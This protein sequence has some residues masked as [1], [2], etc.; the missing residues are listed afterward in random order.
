MPQPEG[1]ALNQSISP[2]LTQ[3][4]IGF[5]PTFKEYIARQIFP[6]I[7]V[8]A[9]T[10][11]Y[12]IWRQGDF[13]RRGG[14]K[15]SNYEAPPIEGFSTDHGSYST[16]H[17]GV[18]T[19]YTAKDLANARLAGTSEATHRMNKTRFVTGRGLLE[20]EIEVAALCQ[21]SANWTNTWAGVTSGASTNQFIGWDQ[22]AAVPVDDIIAAKEVFRMTTGFEPNKIVIPIQVWNKMRSNASLID[23]IKYGGTMD[24][25]TEVTLQQL[26]ALFEIDQ[27]V[28]PKGVY[29]TAAEGATDAYSYIWTDTVWMGHVTPTPGLETPSAGYLFAWN[30][31]A[32]AGLPQGASG[33]GTSGP[34]PWGSTQS[35]EG[36]FIRTYDQERPQGRFIDCERFDQ[37]NV[38][39]ASLGMTF[40]NAL[41]S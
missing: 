1:A 16:D 35:E 29:N 8:A 13:Y 22:T 23:R 11:Q 38:T 33:L 2:F 17:W 3:L 34:N 21:T 37:A 26:M 18:S 36:L 28:V 12:N 30:G 5:I 39:A 4:A 31:D 6:T 14:K 32:T 19:V 27:I 15:L 24:R 10:G 20:R 40:T 41:A 7:P 25:P 9:P